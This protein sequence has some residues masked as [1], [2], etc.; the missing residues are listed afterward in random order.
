MPVA[1][2][3]DIEIAV[4]EQVEKHGNGDEQISVLLDELNKGND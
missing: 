3:S 1:T 2:V 4:D